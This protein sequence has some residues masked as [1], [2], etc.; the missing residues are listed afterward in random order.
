MWSTAHVQVFNGRKSYEIPNGKNY[1]CVLESFIWINKHK[2]K[3]MRMD[4]GSVSARFSE[5]LEWN[6]LNGTCF[7]F[8]NTLKV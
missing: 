1:E 6:R 5:V 2:F 7:I 4:F 8:E 3:L